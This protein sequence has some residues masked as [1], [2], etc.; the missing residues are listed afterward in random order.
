MLL[1]NT[2]PMSPFLENPCSMFL[3]THLCIYTSIQGGNFRHVCSLCFIAFPVP[4]QWPRIYMDTKL[5]CQGQHDTTQYGQDS[6]FSLSNSS[7]ENICPT[8]YPTNLKTSLRET[9]LNLYLCNVF[10]S[11]LSYCSLP[12]FL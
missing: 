6:S 5:Q 12:I 10:N 3:K 1:R 8:K 11:S 9:S 7:P 2:A 4:Q